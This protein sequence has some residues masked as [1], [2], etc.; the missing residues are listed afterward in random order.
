MVMSNYPPPPGGQQ[1]PYGPPPGGQGQQ[2]YGAPP[3]YGQHYGQQPYGQ[4]PYGQVPYG[5]APYGQAPYGYG[6]MPAY[7][8]WG[9][10]V[11]ATLLDYLISLVFLVPMFLGVALAVAGSD[12]N[13]NSNTGLIAVGAIL[14]LLGWLGGLVFQIWNYCVRQ[15]RTGATIGKKVVGIRLV[16]ESTGRPI[17]GWLCFGRMFVH[18]IDS[19]VFYLGYLWPL[20]DAKRQTWTDKVLSTVVIEGPPV[21]K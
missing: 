6:T 18:V 17:G 1:D 12:P 19:A 16:S 13:G 7:A 9:A 5:Q 10:R 11:G 8:S 21:E 14:A 4:A 2:A 3:S 15:G 20:W